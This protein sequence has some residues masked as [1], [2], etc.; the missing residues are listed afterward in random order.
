MEKCCELDS[1]HESITSTNGEEHVDERFLIIA[2]FLDIWDKRQALDA[3]ESELVE[4]F[5]ENVT[6]SNTLT[7][8]ET[9]ADSM[10]SY[11]GEKST[12]F[13]ASFFHLYHR[14]KYPLF[15]LIL[16]SFL[17]FRTCFIGKFTNFRNAKFSLI[18]QT[19]C[20]SGI[21]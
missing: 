5:D 16:V 15:F 4:L 12:Y 18:L 19:L 2:P 11:I 3:A 8:S 13:L 14:L 17:Y 20:L 7:G 9:V 21:F 10:T 6:V 1:N